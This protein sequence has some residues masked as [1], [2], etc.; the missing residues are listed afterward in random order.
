[1][2]SLRSFASSAVQF[3]SYT[4]ARA[5]TYSLSLSLS[6]KKVTRP[7]KSRSDPPI[8]RIIPLSAPTNPD[9]GSP[10]HPAG[11]LFGARLVFSVPEIISIP[12]FRSVERRDDPR[13]RFDRCST[14]LSLSPSVHLS[15][16]PS[17]FSLSTKLPLSF[18]LFPFNKILSLPFLFVLE[19]GWYIDKVNT[20]S[21]RRKN[22]SKVRLI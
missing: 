12:S 2:L 11:S 20:R 16:Y 6:R 9:K 18:S 13:Q 22:S 21:S 3:L 5:H 10:R 1:M 14:T 17:F 19:E 8:P 4:R 7:K 15:P